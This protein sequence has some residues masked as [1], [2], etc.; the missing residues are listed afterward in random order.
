M[1][2]VIQEPLVRRELST[3]GDLNEKTVSIRLVGGQS[4][5]SGVSKEVDSVIIYN[6]LQ[7]RK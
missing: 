6:R 2:N 5:K 3:E 1:L 7:F 4:S